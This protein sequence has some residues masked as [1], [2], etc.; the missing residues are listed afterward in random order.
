ML[1]EKCGK[2]E[3]NVYMKNVINGETTERHLCSECANEEGIL[4]TAVNPFYGMSSF[5][6]NFNQAFQGFFP[7]LTAPTAGTRGS[8][9]AGTT[10]PVCGAP[11]AEI[12]ACPA[13]A[14]PSAE[15]PACPVCAVPPAVPSRTLC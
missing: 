13:C 5:F 15:I 14:V 1:C 7:G 10:C 12:P 11:P 9:A 6:D 4:K 8:L 3:A 2:R